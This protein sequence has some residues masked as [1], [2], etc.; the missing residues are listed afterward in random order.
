MNLT[1]FLSYGELRDGWEQVT[2][3]TRTARQQ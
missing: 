3:V 2:E 1:K